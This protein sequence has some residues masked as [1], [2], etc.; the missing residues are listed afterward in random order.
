MLG[1]TLRAL[2]ITILVS[3]WPGTGAAQVPAP[4]AD[5]PASLVLLRNGQVIEGRVQRT[6]DHYEIAMPNGEIRLRAADVEFVCRDLEEGYQRKRASIGPGSIQGHLDLAQWCLRHELLGCAANE[7]SAAMDIDPEHPMVAMLHRR[8]KAAMEKPAAAPRPAA[9]ES[10]VPTSEE[11][12]RL[13]RGMPPGTV[14]GFAQVVQPILIH[15]C[16]TGGCHAS[17]TEKHL[18]LMRPP[19]GQPTTRRL[20]QRNL[21]AVLQW[22]D[23]DNPAASKLLSAASGPHGT[24]RAA[25]FTDRQ[26]LQYRRL[27][28]WVYQVAQQPA[29]DVTPDLAAEM[30]KAD[31]FGSNDE[32]GPPRPLPVKP[33]ARLTPRPEK[34]LRPDAIPAA[35]EAP[36]AEG[37]SPKPARASHAAHP[38][39][40]G[41]ESD[42]RQTGPADDPF[43]PEAFNRQFGASAAPGSAAPATLP[44]PAAKALKEKTE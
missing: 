3:G 6:A 20:T 13:V 25:V 39:R 19:L 11:L 38:I 40:Q 7:I 9:A 5:A 16:M 2:A 36:V 32:A 30:Q 29:P 17:P 22:V 37:A 12:D 35:A 14:E 23:R 28:E 21:H 41:S 8:L 27:L 10:K 26:V 33:R 44:T 24:N 31:A 15:H 34:R 1:N 4:P 42:R 43:D 18:R